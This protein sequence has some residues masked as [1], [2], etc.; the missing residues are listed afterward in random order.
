MADQ[1][2]RSVVDKLEKFAQDLNDD[3]REVLGELLYHATGAEGH[4]EGSATLHQAIANAA[5][6]S[7]T[8]TRLTLD[9][10][11]EGLVLVAKGVSSGRLA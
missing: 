8:N 7:K 11:P 2:L 6:G 10:A 9:E 5:S 1:P 3:E 4:T